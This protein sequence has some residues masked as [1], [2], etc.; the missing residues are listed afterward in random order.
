MAKKQFVEN[1]KCVA[2]FLAT[3]D[4]E[5]GGIQQA[6]ND[7]FIF[8]DYFVE[9]K[10]ERLEL[11]FNKTSIAFSREIAEKVDYDEFVELKMILDDIRERLREVNG[12]NY[13]ELEESIVYLQLLTGIKVSLY[14][15]YVRTIQKL[16]LNIVIS[17]YARR[18]PEQVSAE[19]VK[20]PKED[21]PKIR[22]PRIKKENPNERCEGKKPS[23]GDEEFRD[24]YFVVFDRQHKKKPRH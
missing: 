22:R 11:E 4:L 8:G 23:V 15:A 18:R 10:R 21:R 14:T 7:E 20:R 5:N 19:R 9:S 1:A 6:E 12:D 3:T 17:R 2:R 24:K 13:K 16:A